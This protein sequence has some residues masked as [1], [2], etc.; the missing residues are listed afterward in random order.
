M[1]T[2]KFTLNELKS[3][4]KQIIKEE[5]TQMFPEQVWGEGKLPPAP[6]N[7]KWDM[8]LADLAKSYNNPN[9][10]VNDLILTI[11]GIAK[12]TTK[13]GAYQYWLNSKKQPAQ[14]PQK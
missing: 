5:T 9:V 8:I 14:Q 2:K 13:S 1:A 3:L 4:V 6:D 12:G 11:G 10:N 7:Q